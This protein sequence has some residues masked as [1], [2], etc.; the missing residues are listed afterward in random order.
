MNTM[1]SYFRHRCSF[2]SVFLNIMDEKLNKKG[3]RKQKRA[4]HKLLRDMNIKCC[5]DPTQVN[6]YLCCY[7]MM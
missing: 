3:H 4:C 2:W 6:I 7:H 5:D 1:L